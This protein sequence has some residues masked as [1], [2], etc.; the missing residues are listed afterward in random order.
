MSNS[1][2]LL[3]KN[4]FLLVSGYAIEKETEQSRLVQQNKNVY[5]QGVSNG[6]V[7]YIV[8]VMSRVVY[9]TYACYINRSVI[10]ICLTVS[11]NFIIVYLG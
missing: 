11:L 8:T 1:C 10:S 2:Q 9:N 3:A 4:G 6:V 5:S 7:Q